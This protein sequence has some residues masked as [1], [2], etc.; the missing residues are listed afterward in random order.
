MFI[1][2]DC[3]RRF[4]SAAGVP[5]VRLADREVAGL[6]RDFLAASPD[7]PGMHRAL[8]AAGLDVSG[9]TDR[10]MDWLARLLTAHTESFAD[11]SPRA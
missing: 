2:T 11:R 9:R 6:A 8:I 7:R 1:D 3:A 10:D 4:F 5:V